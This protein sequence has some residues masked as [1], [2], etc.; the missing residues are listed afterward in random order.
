MKNSVIAYLVRLFCILVASTPALA[1]VEI[2][3][4][5]KYGGSSG[6]TFD[7]V[8]GEYITMIETY[9]NDEHD[10]V[11]LTLTFSDGKML[12]L[13]SVTGSD[14][15]INGSLDIVSDSISVI[16]LLQ[17]DLGG[18]IFGIAGIYIETLK[19][20]V[21]STMSNPDVSDWTLVKCSGNPCKN[22][23]LAGVSGSDGSYID[24]L[25]FYY[26]QDELIYRVVKDISYRNLVQSEVS[27]INVASATVGNLTN[28]TQ[29]SSI[30]FSE[31]IGS[32]YSW[33]S[34]SGIAVGTQ[35]EFEAGI[36]FVGSGKVTVSAEVSFEYTWGQTKSVSK[37]FSYNADIQVAPGASVVA[38][39]TASTY[40]ITGDFTATLSDNWRHA[41]AVSTE[42]EGSVEGLAAYVVDVEYRDSSDESK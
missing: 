35:A 38:T 26:Y 3:Q 24:S 18:D 34:T 16:Y 4:T 11:G 19:G 5:E 40:E 42:F 7:Y 32:D 25:S 37:T 13:G 21:L 17:R 31:S 39:A 20:E 30:S 15:S 27:P 14:V 9:S 22:I 6:G 28:E 10:L 2:Q 1:E 12:S 36:P 8:F 23:Y 33:S 29:V 41:G